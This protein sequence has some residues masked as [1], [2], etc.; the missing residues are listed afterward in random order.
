MVDGAH[1]ATGLTSPT[2]TSESDSRMQIHV[3]RPLDGKSLGLK[4]RENVVVQVVDQRAYQFGWT[5]GDRVHAVN[6][7]PVTDLD[8]FSTAIAGAIHQ[9][10]LTQRPIM[11]SIS[12][13]GTKNREPRRRGDSCC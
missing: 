13:G 2:A 12:R 6:G 11:F 8:S 3:S 5:V 10:Q 9:W 7:V 1:S 4:V